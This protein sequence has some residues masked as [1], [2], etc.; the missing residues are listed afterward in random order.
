MS[1]NPSLSYSRLA[2]RIVQGAVYVFLGATVLFF[3]L[4][5]TEAGRDV[6]RAQ[7]QSAF[8]ERFEPGEVT[9][10]EEVAD[11]VAFAATQESSTVH[12]IDLYRRDKFEGW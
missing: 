10:P 4:T 7:V 9:E 1:E 3:A 12:E 5:R 2:W 11:A 8:N 6:L